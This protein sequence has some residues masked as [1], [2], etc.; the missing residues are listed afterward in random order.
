[1]QFIPLYPWATTEWIDTVRNFDKILE[2]RQSELENK[3]KE[4]RKRFA[5]LNRARER[6]VGNAVSTRN[7]LAFTY[8]GVAKFREYQAALEKC[9]TRIRERL[10]FSDL[11]ALAACLFF[12]PALAVAVTRWI[13]SS[14]PDNIRPLLEVMLP[15][16][17][18]GLIVCILT[19]WASRKACR[20]S[21]ERLE[22]SARELHLFVGKIPNAV[23]SYRLAA[24]GTGQYAV[25]RDRIRVLIDLDSGPEDLEHLIAREP[26]ENLADETVAARFKRE[27]SART[28]KSHGTANGSS[29]RYERRFYRKTTVAGKS[30]F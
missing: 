10:N 3:T 13:S 9:Q 7:Q 21:V 17:G 16:T 11:I 1:M 23:N 18:I 12:V 26:P 20:M 28:L 27:F 22:R 8:H 30:I 19:Y 4:F 5:G 2:A 24:F 29:T 15:A 14:N 25:V 6:S